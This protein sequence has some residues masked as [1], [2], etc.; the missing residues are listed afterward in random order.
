MDAYSTH[1][2]SAIFP[3]PLEFRPERWLRDDPK[4]PDGSTPLSRY[5]VSFTR[6]SRG[7]LGMNL[8][9]MELYVA[10]ATAFRRHRFEL[11]ETTVEDVE[12]AID[13]IKPMPKWGSKGVRAR[14]M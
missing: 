7:C 3:S 9:F 2:N 5:V 11:F 4:G 1:A 12:F 6:G 8:A 14:V 10:L 13:L